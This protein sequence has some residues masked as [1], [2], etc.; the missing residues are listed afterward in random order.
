MGARISFALATVAAVAAGVAWH[1]ARG[2]AARWAAPALDCDAIYRPVSGQDGKDVMWLRSADAVIDRMLRI[3]KVTPADR[4]VDLG[5]GDGAIPIAAARTFGA[6]A[7]GV[8]LNPDLVRLAR[9]RS[10]AA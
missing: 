7:R 10:T 1:A 5:A 8:E 2:A 3:A 6:S 9:C 4:V